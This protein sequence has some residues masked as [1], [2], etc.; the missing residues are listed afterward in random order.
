MPS[1]V[2]STGSGTVNYTVAANQ[3]SDRTGT[4][5]IAGQTFTVNQKGSGSGSVSIPLTTGWNLIS[6]PIQPT[7]TAIATVLNNIS[8][9]YTII[10]SYINGVWK[11]YDPSDVPGSTLTTIEAGAGYW[12]KMPSDKTL[13]V[14]GT[15]APASISLISG[16]NLTGYNKTAKADASTVLM[17]IANKYIIVWSYMNGVWKLYDPSDVPGSTL[18]EFL[19]DYGYWI[20]MKEAAIWSQ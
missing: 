6:A 9:S 10:W 1:N 13:A 14:S 5:T 12:I 2:G 8:G 11:L 20:K 15:V 17:S 3:G 7:N 16:W 19:P 4:M 18:T